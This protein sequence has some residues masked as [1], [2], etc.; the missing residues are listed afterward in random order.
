VRTAVRIEKHMRL[1][2]SH[3]AR[4]TTNTNGLHISVCIYTRIYSLICSRIFAFMDAKVAKEGVL[5][6]HGVP[7]DIVAEIAMDPRRFD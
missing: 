6:G 5:V 3:T 4:S 1:F 2:R 7:Q